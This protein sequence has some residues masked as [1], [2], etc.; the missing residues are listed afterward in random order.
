MQIENIYSQFSCKR[1]PLR[2]KCL[3]LALSAYENYFFKQ[4]PKKNRVDV[5]FGESSLASF[6]LLGSKKGQISRGQIEI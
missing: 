4:T 2:K 6:V 5:R 1:S 3:L